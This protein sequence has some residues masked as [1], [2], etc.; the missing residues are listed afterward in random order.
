[1][2][3]IASL[4]GRYAVI[5]KVCNKAVELVGQA[6]IEALRPFRRQGQVKTLTYD[7]GKEFCG[8]AL[9]DE[10]LK[11]TGYFARPFA[12]TEFGSYVDLGLCQ[13]FN[14]L[15]RQYVPKTRPIKSVN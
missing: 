8:H 6:I 4:T 7:N 10:A 15:L 9:I 3:L 2:T 11:S 1:M 12:N 5:A 13:S 14:G